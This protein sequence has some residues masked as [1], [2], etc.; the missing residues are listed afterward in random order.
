ML[1]GA[2]GSAVGL[3][4]GIAF[5]AAAATSLGTMT[6]NP[7]T[8]V[9]AFL[10]FWYLALNDGGKSAN[11]DFAGWYGAATPAVQFMYALLAAGML[12]AAET[13]YRWKQARL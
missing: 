1:A 4:I 13:Q 12:I 6:S 7:K 5:T 11:F 8:F 9:V 10:L 2:H 3:L